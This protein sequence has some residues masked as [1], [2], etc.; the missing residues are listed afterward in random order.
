MER[1]LLFVSS[2]IP[3]FFSGGILETSLYLP[4]PSY[5]AIIITATVPYFCLFF[6]NIWKLD[7]E[8]RTGV[9]FVFC[10][11]FRDKIS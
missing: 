4:S 10:Y 8:G 9:A 7:V 2:E 6:S 11:N 5:D 1:K 3:I